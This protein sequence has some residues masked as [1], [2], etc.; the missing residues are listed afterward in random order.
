[1]PETVH[2]DLHQFQLLSEAA[3]E[4]VFVMEEGVIRF[5]NRAG[6]T[7]LGYSKEEMVDRTAIDLIAPKWRKKAL[8]LMRKGDAAPLEIQALRKDGSRISLEMRG[9]HIPKEGGGTYYIAT[10]LD[11]THRHKSDEALQQS[12]RMHRAIVN[13]TAEG[14]WM[15]DSGA[16]TME[17]N[18]ALC[19]MLG[20]TR[21][22]MIGKSPLEFV[23]GKNREIVQYQI[24]QIKHTEHRIYEI[25]ITRKNG[26]LLPVLFHSTTLLDEKREPTH[27]FAFVTDISARKK[28]EKELKDLNNRLEQR[29]EQEIRIRM[30][31]ERMLIHQSRLASMG[32]MIAS[33]AHQWRQPLNALGLYIQDLQEAYDNGELS[34]EYL[35]SAVAISMD[36]IQHMSRTIDDFRNFFKQEKEKEL[37]SPEEATR[38]A[39]SIV[40]A[41]LRANNISVSLESQEKLP[42]IYGF[43]GEFKQAILNILSNARDAILEKNESGK[44]HILMKEHRQDLRMTIADSGGGI[45]PK[46]LPE[47]FTP[48]FSTKHHQGMGIGLHMSRI[49]IE[50]HMNGTLQ[51]ANC[52]QGACFTITLPSTSAESSPPVHTPSASGRTTPPRP[53]LPASASLE[54]SP[55]SSG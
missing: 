46:I 31:K 15:L 12:E 5:A 35:D 16:I 25:E 24:S 17:V 11:L 44:I 20:F 10:A 36:Q 50:D 13:T 26:A 55:S 7:L 52:N 3:F 45:D 23:E 28:M 22:E 4:G 34:R 1:M 6:A 9:R 42:G 21:E 49:I 14:F 41:Q 37:F 38:S 30:E 33:I 48:Y 8:L 39:L 2:Q 47:I 29:V 40:E 51:A 54:G 18:D 19:N 32:E 43:P 27:S 53:E